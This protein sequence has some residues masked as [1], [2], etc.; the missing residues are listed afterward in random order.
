M[1]Q[2]HKLRFSISIVYRFKRRMECT[3][4]VPHT[5]TQQATNSLAYT[6]RRTRQS[7]T[8][9]MGLQD[10]ALRDISGPVL[11]RYK[12][13]KMASQA[14]QLI[15]SL[16]HLGWVK[17]G[18]SYIRHKREDATTEYRR[19]TTVHWNRQERPH[20]LDHYLVQRNPLS[21]R[22]NYTT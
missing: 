6:V 15:S 12:N 14:L 20:N 3:G 5:S 17:H 2:C 18:S 19:R 9:R 13:H 21:A 1:N 4:R 16:V 11:L 10:F 22:E 8:A 7:E